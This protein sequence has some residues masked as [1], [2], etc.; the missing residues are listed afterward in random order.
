MDLHFR[1]RPCVLA[2]ALPCAVC[3]VPIEPGRPALLSPRS[4][5]VAHRACGEVLR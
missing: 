3:A 2:R 5:S 4:G 1:G